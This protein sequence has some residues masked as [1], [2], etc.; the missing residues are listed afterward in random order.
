[1]ALLV[2][3]YIWLLPLK[4]LSFPGQRLHLMYAPE[5]W[6]EFQQYETIVIFNNLKVKKIL[7]KPSETLGIPQVS[8]YELTSN[9]IIWSKSMIQLLQLKIYDN[10][11]YVISVM[12]LLSHKSVIICMTKITSMLQILEKIE[13]LPWVIVFECRN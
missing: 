12:V 1:M 7:T 13:N 2:G 5:V 9:S 3:L 11:K 4:K 10:R 6:K 8:N